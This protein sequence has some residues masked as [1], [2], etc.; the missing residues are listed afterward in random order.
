MFIK[1][2][3]LS[4]N[5]AQEAANA[6]IAPITSLKLVEI[7]FYLRALQTISCKRTYTKHVQILEIIR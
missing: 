2:P 6:R 4:V 7:K 1:T 3:D 5:D